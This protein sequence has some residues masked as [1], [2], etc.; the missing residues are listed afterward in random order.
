MKVYVCDYDHHKTTKHWIEYLKQH[1]E[2]IVS[3][4]ANPV[5]AEWADV[6]YIEW[7]ENSAQILAKGEGHFDDVY[8]HEGVRGEKGLTYSGDFNWK[9]KPMHIR[10][11]D[12]D[13][14]YGH[15]RGVDWANVTSLIWI[16]PHIGRLLHENITYPETL[17]Q[18]FVP[19]SVKLS[20]WTY[21]ERTGEG[22]KIAWVNHN[23]AA[24]GLPLMIQAFKKLI[25]FS[26]DKTWELHI[27]ENGRSTE[28]WLHAYVKYM[29]SHF[30]LEDNVRWHESVPNVDEFL[31]D[32]DYLVSSSHKEAFSLILA[33]A[34]AKGIKAITHSWWGADELWPQ[35]MIWYTVDEFPL[36][37]VMNGPYN[38]QHYKELAEKYSSEKE[39]AALREITGL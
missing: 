4:Y 26:G 18:Y 29:I 16:A 21:K 39:I 24:K 17:K 35:E 23:W 11:I 10:P 25:D 6:I 13:V 3:M 32:K 20:D 5:Y 30:G 19:L 2:V 36:K 15:F 31:E 12:I 7:C 33:E 38:S 22:K 1:H 27:V 8:D 37:L 34:M 9:G 28:Y 14:Y